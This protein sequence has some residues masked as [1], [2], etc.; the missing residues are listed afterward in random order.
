MA[1][2]QGEHINA[3]ETKTEELLRQLRQ[4]QVALRVAT[5]EKF[6][7]LDQSISALS[8]KTQASIDALSAK[9]QASLDALSAKTQASIDALS[10]TVQRLQA[11]RA[12]DT[13]AILAMLTSMRQERQ[14]PAATSTSLHMP[15]D[16]ASV[17]LPALPSPAS[18]P[19]VAPDDVLPP[20]G[21]PPEIGGLI[22]TTLSAPRD[23][24]KGET[25]GAYRACVHKDAKVFLGGRLPGETPQDYKHRAIMRMAWGLACREHA[26]SANAE[27]SPVRRLRPRKPG[28]VDLPKVGPEDPKDPPSSSDFRSRSA[29]VRATH[30][31]SSRPQWG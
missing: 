29:P 14:V 9:T 1:P 2:T 5:R 26:T 11:S 4:E 31:A 25:E 20:I 23:E 8:A 12:K 30:R 27:V 7:T 28:G 22:F 6:A 3:L 10:A 15:K 21:D 16:P 24:A 18:S 13:A 17:A 19:V